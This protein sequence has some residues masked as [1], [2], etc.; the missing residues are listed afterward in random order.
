[1]MDL[2]EWAKRE[3]SYR[4]DKDRDAFISRSLLRMMEMLKVLRAQAGRRHRGQ[5][6]A[7][8]VLLVVLLLLVVTARTASFL[9]TVLGGELLLMTALSGAQLRK[10]VAGALT[11]AFFCLL[12]IVPALVFWGAGP[13]VLLPVKTFLCVTALNLLQQYFSWHEVTAALRRFHLPPEVIFI[14]DTT[15]RYLVVLGDQ[16]SLLLTSLKLCSVGHNPRKHRAMAGIMGIVVQR[17][18]RLSLEMAEAMRC[19]CFTGEYPRLEGPREKG[20]LL[21]RLIPCLLVAFYAFLYLRL[22]GFL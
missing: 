17:S 10:I 11:A 12:L 2:P 20:S 19:R 15:L 16:A 8:L 21:G 1:M 14:L 13:V 22:E 7:A 18:Q 9:W 6:G 4:P 3:E 5:A